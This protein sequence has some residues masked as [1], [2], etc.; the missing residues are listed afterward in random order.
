MSI[1]TKQDFLTLSNTEGIIFRDEILYQLYVNGASGTGSGSV[2]PPKT[3]TGA[4]NPIG[5]GA[6][7]Q[8]SD[9]HTILSV[10]FNDDF[11]GVANLQYSYDE[12]QWVFLNGN[13][14][15]F[16][17]D[18]GRSAVS[19]GLMSGSALYTLNILGAKY[20]R[21]DF[22]DVTAG[23]GTYTFISTVGQPLDASQNDMIAVLQNISQREDEIKIA[24]YDTNNGAEG[25]A[26]LLGKEIYPFVSNSYTITTN[27]TTTVEN[28]GQR[29]L[30]IQFAGTWT[31]NINFKIRQLGISTGVLITGNNVILNE[32]TGAGVTAGTIT[33]N[34]VYSL[35]ITGIMHI[36][37]VVSSITG[38]ITTWALTTK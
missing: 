37:I 7:F 30:V 31:G 27:S 2:E 13:E 29:K 9:S 35:D 26:T 20:Y 22:G 8:P 16:R 21:V 34:G 25:I 1:L 33:S 38:S 6:T 19:G 15:I 17:L 32:A 3:L 11:T 14:S 24:S 18:L 12:V 4:Y 10:I 28:D 23:V 36:D 5:V